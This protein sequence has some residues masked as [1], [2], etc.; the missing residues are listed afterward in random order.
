MVLQ[1]DACWVAENSQASSLECYLSKVLENSWEKCYLGL[2][3]LWKTQRLGPAAAFL[4]KNKCNRYIKQLRSGEA[5][6]EDFRY[7]SGDI[8]SRAFPLGQADTL[9]GVQSS[10]ILKET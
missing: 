8:E 2:L 5:G 10:A 6:R 7:V 1:L 4:E 9:E 3:E